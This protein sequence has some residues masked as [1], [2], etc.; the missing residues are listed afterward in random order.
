MSD[1]EV[2]YEVRD[3]VA[4]LT[5]N[6]P[7]RRN[8]WTNEMQRDYFDLLERACHDDQ[9]KVI[10]LTGAGRSFC[11]GA[12]AGLLGDIS[13]APEIPMDPRG[14]RLDFALHVP[15]P[16][17]AA[18]NGAA[19]GIG[20]VAT[21]QCDLRFA[22]RGIKLT[23]AFTRRGLVAETGSSWLLPQL[24]GRSRAAD[25]L[26]S[27]RV[28]LAEEALQM[29]LVD[30]VVEGDELMPAV[31]AY[32][33]DLVANCSPEAMATVKHQLLEHSTAPYDAS[34]V[35]SHDWTEK[36]LHERDF[37]EGLQSFVE[38]RSPTFAGLSVPITGGRWATPDVQEK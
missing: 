18:I 31:L 20:L 13:A 30:R 28:V 2:A 5:L 32:A 36:S 35:E 25:L 9:V 33:G 15:K 24:V 26:L 11:V 17:I 38:G 10:V 7:D 12:D 27:A 8:S 16:M 37:R 29:G 34:Y 21:L 23:T 6:R 19:A 3:Q 14:R 1:P 4:V 22:A